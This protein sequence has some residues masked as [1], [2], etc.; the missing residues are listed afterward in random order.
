M[1]EFPVVGG[2]RIERI[3]ELQN[4][5]LQGAI[6]GWSAWKD[7]HLDWLAG[8]EGQVFENEFAVRADGRFSPVGCH[9]FSIEESVGPGFGI[10]T[11]ADDDRSHGAER[12]YASPMVWHD[13]LLSGQGIPPFLMTARTGGQFKPPAPQNRDHLI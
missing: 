1:Q 10:E 4:G 11:A 13:H 7:E 2:D 12:K 3:V 9:E 6:F 5:V 8:F